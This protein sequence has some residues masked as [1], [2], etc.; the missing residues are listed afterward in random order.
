[1]TLYRA[2]AVAVNSAP[3]RVLLSLV[4]CVVL[5]PAAIWL[6]YVWFHPYGQRSDCAR[7][8]LLALRLYAEDNAGWFPQG[9]DTPLESLQLLYP[10]YCRDGALLAGMSGDLDATTQ[11]L[12]AGEPLDAS[13]SSWVYHP[14][15]RSDDPDEIAILWESR[16]GI[17]MVGRRMLGGGRVVGYASCRAELIPRD[18]WPAF[19]Q[20]QEELRAEVLDRRR[21]MRID[22]GW[23]GARGGRGREGGVSPG[24]RAE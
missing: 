17:S 5:P 10:H 22:E 11:R 8:T 2:I 7:Q 23:R 20:E 15:F 12:A 18:E 6:G 1:M 9:A 24:I 3:A 13:A 21:E 14:G 19:L 4:L 16:H